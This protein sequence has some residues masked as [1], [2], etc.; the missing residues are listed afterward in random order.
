LISPK[1]GWR[2]WDEEVWVYKQ[3]DGV[4][5]IDDAVLVT[6]SGAATLWRT[7]EFEHVITPGAI[8]LSQRR[9]PPIPSCL[10]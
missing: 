7:V 4:D 9:F 1:P 10:V 3:F 8:N 5:W 6:E 2:V